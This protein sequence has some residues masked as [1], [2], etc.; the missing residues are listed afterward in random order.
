MYLRIYLHARWGAT[1]SDSCLFVCVYVTSLWL[2]GSPN[3]LKTKTKNITRTKNR[4]KSLETHL[5]LS[6]VRSLLGQRATRD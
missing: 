6:V 1:V 2:I 5:K 4:S 3:E